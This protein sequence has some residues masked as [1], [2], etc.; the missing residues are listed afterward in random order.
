MEKILS[1]AIPE[2]RSIDRE[3]VSLANSLRLQSKKLMLRSRDEVARDYLNAEIACERLRDKLN[4][5]DHQ[6]RPPIAN[7]QYRKLLD[8]FRSQLGVSTPK[9][10]KRVHVEEEIALIVE[11]VE[12]G[13]QKAGFAELAKQYVH[14]QDSKFSTEYTLPALAVIVLLLARGIS[15]FD[16]DSLECLE[17][18]RKIAA[19]VKLNAGMSFRNI[20]QRVWR[21]TEERKLLEGF[22]ISTRNKTKSGPNECF[23][24]SSIM[25]FQPY[26][27][28]DEAVS[29]F[30][31]WKLVIM[32]QIRRGE[33]AQR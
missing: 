2:L 27:L 7:N 12:L 31:E 22:K 11:K 15:A 23:E 25:D 30:E 33:E 21:E 18:T 19:S 28:S 13:S 6:F 29:Q 10:R 24:P 16:D 32:E 1:D 3:L 8:Q 5:P 17:T 4:L 9:K 14:D 26:F 20:I